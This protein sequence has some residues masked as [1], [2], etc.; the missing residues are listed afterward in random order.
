MACSML[1]FQII[2]TFEGPGTWYNKDS[3]EY[4]AK[5]VINVATD[6]YGGVGFGGCRLNG[7]H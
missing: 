6:Q 7:C 3:D 1:G 5:R 2:D 4:E